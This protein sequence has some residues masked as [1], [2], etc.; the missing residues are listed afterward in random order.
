MV[1]QSKQPAGNQ[2]E[3]SDAHQTRQ[4]ISS[5][6]AVTYSI[7]MMIAGLRGVTGAG[8]SPDCQK[9]DEGLAKMDG[10]FNAFG[11]LIDGM[12]AKHKL[13]AEL[14]PNPTNKPSA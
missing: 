9:I 2:P 6:S 14:V 7:R 5:A 10:L 11:T 12:A 13:I 3:Q 1:T 4:V 8:A